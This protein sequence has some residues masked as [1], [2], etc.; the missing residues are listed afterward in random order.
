MRI[1]AIIPSIVISGL[2]SI[3][4]CAFQVSAAGKTNH[5]LELPNVDLLKDSVVRSG[6]D[7]DIAWIPDD[8]RYYIVFPANGE[9]PS[10]EFT[11]NHSCAFVDPYNFESPITKWYM[12]MFGY[13]CKVYAGCVSTFSARLL[14]T[15]TLS[16][17]CSSQFWHIFQRVA[18]NPIG[19]MLL[20]RILIEVCRRDSSGYPCEE[21]QENI[22]FIFNNN[23][24]KYL[25]LNICKTNDDNW[26]FDKA[27]G[28]IV[29]SLNLPNYTS[30]M[31]TNID[32]Y[33]F[34]TTTVRLTDR[35]IVLFHELLHWFHCIR[36]NDRYT[37]DRTS[38]S[39]DTL[40]PS[41]YTFY[42][43]SKQANLSPWLYSNRVKG[44]EMIEAGEKMIEEGEKMIEEGEKVRNGAIMKVEGKKMI[45]EGTE[46]QRKGR[47]KRTEEDTKVQGEE[48]RTI[49]GYNTYFTSQIIE[50]PN[51]LAGDELSE[52]LYR[53]FLPTYLHFTDVPVNNTYFRFGH[54]TSL[55]NP[56]VYQEIL[57]AFLVTYKTYST[58][59]TYAQ[60]DPTWIKSNIKDFI[61][62]FSAK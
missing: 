52:N 31:L 3:V 10:L 50:A 44:N 16:E 19:R 18:A 6:L 17:E 1:F 51:Y 39:V 57:R 40:K 37:A 47:E 60:C 41:I 58:I 13:Q 15:S 32:K 27:E 9:Q 24:N 30:V 43:E 28:K 56:D 12:Y 53:A 5:R 48:M 14:D 35:S 2:C 21:K 61:K 38:I 54:G 22:G 42:Y 7:D 49:L 26:R 4:L 23:R 8:T 59:L 34:A 62:N 29:Y 11:L 20:Y 46:M 45:K 33:Q 55:C 25:S 36:K